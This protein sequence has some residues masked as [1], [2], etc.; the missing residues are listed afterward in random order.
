M[1]RSIILVPVVVVAGMIAALDHAS[2]APVTI[3]VFDIPADKFVAI[4]SSSNMFEIR[5]SELAQTK[6]GSEAIKAFATQMIE[7]HTKAQDD[8]AASQGSLP[9]AE[10]SPKH[11]A[12]IALLEG[13]SNGDFDM[14]YT[15]MQAGAHTEA[16]SLFASYS[17]NGTDPQLK[18]FAAATLPHLE[19]HKM[20]IDK[21][22][23]QP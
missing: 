23:A 4:V 18:T 8:L 6:S 9:A 17:V 3:A 5:S 16:V 11:T 1:K 12:M 14:L 22:A 2:A 10:M 13:A 7:D 19:E 15:D 20:M 21:I